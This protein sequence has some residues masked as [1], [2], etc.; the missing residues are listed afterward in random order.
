MNKKN[1]LNLKE[2]N[3]KKEWKYCNLINKE[4]RIKN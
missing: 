2:K 4:I 3:W 1:I